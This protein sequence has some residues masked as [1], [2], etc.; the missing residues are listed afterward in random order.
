VRD[1]VIYLILR[2]KNLKI[3]VGQT[4]DVD[5]HINMHLSRSG[6]PC[7]AH[8]INE[9]GLHNLTSVI[10]QAGIKRQHIL[11]MAEI[12]LIRYFNSY[13]YMGYNLTCSGSRK[14]YESSDVRLRESA[15][16]SAA[17][18][19]RP[20]AKNRLNHLH[21]YDYG[22]VI[23]SYMKTLVRLHEGCNFWYYLPALRRHLVSLNMIF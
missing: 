5:Q 20:L 22:L 17:A 12:C 16:L 1:G 19:M 9:Y 11:N 15:S 23:L 21:I 8:D 18:P 14:K 13:S 3:Y 7:L 2:L 10:I 4:R 6:S